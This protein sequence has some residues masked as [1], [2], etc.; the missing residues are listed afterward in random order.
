M[1]HATSAVAPQN[2]ETVQVGDVF[3][4]RAQRPGL[5]EGAVRAVGVVEVLVLAQDGHQVALVPDQRPV[6]ELAA[7]TIATLVLETHNHKHSL[8]SLIPWLLKDASGPRDVR[9]KPVGPQQSKRLRLYYVALTRSTHIVCLAIPK[10]AL[11]E[12][13]E[14]DHRIARLTARGWTI[15]EIV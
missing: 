13:G 9:G 3:W 12:A 10:T 11:G 4:Q 5:V 14:R 6:Q 2:A 7:A 15:K 1:N 8:K